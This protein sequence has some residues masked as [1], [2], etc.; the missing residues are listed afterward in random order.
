MGSMSVARAQGCHCLVTLMFV[1][2]GEDT[3]GAGCVV[4]R[5]G[6]V[7]VYGGVEKAEQR[8]D[9]GMEEERIPESESRDVGEA[10]AVGEQR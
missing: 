9:D 10:V 7:R 8:E 6:E 4:K 2:C 5:G 3:D 1:Q